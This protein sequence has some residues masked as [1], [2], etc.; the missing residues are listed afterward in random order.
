MGEKYLKWKSQKANTLLREGSVK[1]PE[2]IVQRSGLG[3]GRGWEEARNNFI[4]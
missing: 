4:W 1:L 3:R 2:E